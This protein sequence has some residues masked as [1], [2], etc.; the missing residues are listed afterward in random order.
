M[1][2]ALALLLVG[3][4]LTGRTGS[5]PRSGGGSGTPASAPPVGVDVVAA[6]IAPGPLDTVE[7][8]YRLADL[9]IPGL[10]APVEPQG[11]AWIIDLSTL[12]ESPTGP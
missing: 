3:L 6:A 8:S 9:R 1:R 10:R 11:R 7:A 5:T 12:P 2:S 4:A